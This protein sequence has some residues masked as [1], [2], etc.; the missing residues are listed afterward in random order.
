MKRL[1]ESNRYLVLEVQVQVA[2]PP[3]D[4][5][6]DVSAG[7]HAA[8]AARAEVPRHVSL[9]RRGFLLAARERGEE[10]ADRGAEGDHLRAAGGAEEPPAPPQSP[11]AAGDISTW[12]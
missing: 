9:H 11:R 6:R 3:G 4:G 10:A 7:G 1:H 12:T 5:G 8:S 2:S